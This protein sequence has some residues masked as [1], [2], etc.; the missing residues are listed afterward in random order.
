[1]V[2]INCDVP[3][4]TVCANK[5]QCRARLT[6]KAANVAEIIVVKGP[7]NIASAMIDGILLDCR[8][9]R[10]EEWELEGEMSAC[11]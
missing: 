1:M 4:S 11:L 7:L 6:R 5:D 3:L 9:R 2:T 10:D 8:Q